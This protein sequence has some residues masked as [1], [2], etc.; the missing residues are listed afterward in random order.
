MVEV[1]KLLYSPLR[2]I[3]GKFNFKVMVNNN[4]QQTTNNKQQTTKQLNN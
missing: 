2:Q 4:K 3:S 1:S